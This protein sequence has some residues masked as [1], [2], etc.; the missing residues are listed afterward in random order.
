MTTKQIM[1][2]ISNFIQDLIAFHAELAEELPDL[3]IV[4][5]NTQ[6]LSELKKTVQ[7]LFNFLARR[8]FRSKAIQQKTK[9]AV[10]KLML[11]HRLKRT[12]Q[13]FLK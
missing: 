6:H 9:I 2:R 10:S 7:S 5:D 12:K 1:D 13:A 3:R 4:V 8:R 11:R